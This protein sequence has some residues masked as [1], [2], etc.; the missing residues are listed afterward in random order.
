MAELGNHED[1]RT[2]LLAV[3]MNAGGSI[4]L[5]FADWGEAMI[6]VKTL[7]AGIALERSP[8]GIRLS[9][10]QDSIGESIRIVERL[11]R[12]DQQ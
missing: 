8:D 6:A 9:I 10:G 11:K 2:A 1:V 7:S 12:N 5:S 3:L 4:D